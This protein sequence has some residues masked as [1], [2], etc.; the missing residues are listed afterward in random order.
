ML[1]YNGETITVLNNFR[2]T[3]GLTFPI[4]RDLN[5]QVF[6]NYS[7]GYVPHNALI[8][9]AGVIIYTNFGYNEPALISLIENYYQ[10]YVPIAFANNVNLSHGY[11]QM[12]IDTLIITSTLEN[13]G[14]HNAEIYAMVESLDGVYADSLQM[15]DD[16]LHNDSTAG[17]GIYGISMLAPMIE[18][19]YMVGVKTID[20]DLSTTTVFD[21]LDRFTTIG[22]ISVISCVEVSRTSNMIYFQLE[23]QNNGSSL[24][25]KNIFSVV[26]SS[27]PY[28]SA[29]QNISILFGDINAGSSAIG[30]TYFAIMT[31]NLP[32]AHTFIFNFEIFS[33][34]NSFWYDSTNVLVGIAENKNEIPKVFSLKQNY[35]NPFN[36]FTTIEFSIPKSEQV[37]LH[38]N[39]LLGQEV[40]TIVSD[41]LSPGNYKYNWDAGSLASGVYMYKIE[42]GSF[43]QTRK[44]IL[45]K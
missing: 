15:Y 14:N 3:H 22:P 1:N 19:E 24:P 42:A 10:P 25:A 21:D 8:D 39:N 37:T 35:P 44:L 23:L 32:S 6:N 27:D 40:A 30:S 16:G 4:L 20:M 18:Q 5:R 33:N 7:M 34:N 43:I 17:D 45:M 2:T 12:G 11:M 31:N 9:T 29:M 13:L 36:P 41:K 28:I 38:V 26:S